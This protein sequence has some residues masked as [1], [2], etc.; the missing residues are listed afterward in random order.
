[1][2]TFP[3]YH[4]NQKPTTSGNE[5]DLDKEN[6]VSEDSTDLVDNLSINGNHKPNG[7][8]PSGRESNLILQFTTIGGGSNYHLWA[9]EMK[10]LLAEK[11]RNLS[12]CFSSDPPK[13]WIPDELEPPTREQLAEENDPFGF[14]AD[15]FRNKMK[16]R[17]QIIVDMEQDQHPMFATILKHLSNASLQAVEATVHFAEAR[18]TC[19]NITLWNLIKVV[20]QTG[21][22]GGDADERFLEA[23]K[24]FAKLEQGKDASLK[25]YKDNM[26]AA[27]ANIAATN[28]DFM[29]T[30]KILS[31]HFTKNLDSS[32]YGHMQQQAKDASNRGDPLAYA[33]TLTEAYNIALHHE[34]LDTQGKF[35]AADSSFGI[36]AT[37]RLIMPSNSSKSNKSRKAKSKRTETVAAANRSTA[38]KLESNTDASVEKRWCKLCGAEGMPPEGHWMQD[39]PKLDAAKAAISAKT[40]VAVNFS[41]GPRAPSR[42]VII[43]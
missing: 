21:T 9:I 19:N 41:D 1:M 38:K 31:I 14:R 39:C 10:R 13:Y 24:N 6:E 7:K 2:S 5:D 8:L 30:P 3:H 37:G 26:D 15:D 36:C 42:A 35:V 11:Y 22:T 33:K 17:Y 18:D 32:R 12:R 25:S 43:A 20:H 23:L 27:V 34:V 40:K 28:N 16:V 4:R 29:P